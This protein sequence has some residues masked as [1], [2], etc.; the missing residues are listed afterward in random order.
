[1]QSSLKE[2]TD[3]VL[4]PSQAMGFWGTLLFLIFLE[5]SWGQEQTFRPNSYLKD[6][7]HFQIRI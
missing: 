5:Q 3:M 4:I 1:M 7:T 6:K 2:V